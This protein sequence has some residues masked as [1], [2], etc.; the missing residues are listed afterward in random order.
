MGLYMH[1]DQLVDFKIMIEI[2]SSFQIHG[3][4][5]FFEEKLAIVLQINCMRITN[6]RYNP[7]QVSG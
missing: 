6:A 3:S 1:D 2:A 5:V 7:F 4:G